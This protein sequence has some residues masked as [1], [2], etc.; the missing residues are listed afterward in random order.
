MKNLEVF[1]KNLDFLSIPPK[2]SAKQQ[3]VHLYKEVY[4]WMG[5]NTL[6]DFKL[7]ME[8]KDEIMKFS[9]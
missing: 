3:T 4:R 9:K 2:P 8:V 6:K 5:E 1:S 7:H